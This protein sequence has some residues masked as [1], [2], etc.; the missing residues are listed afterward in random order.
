MN[1]KD[2]F[3]PKILITGGIVLVLVVIIWS[4]LANLVAERF[5]PSSTDTL[6]IDITSLS[7]SNTCVPKNQVV[8]WRSTKQYTIQFDANSKCFNA[9][10]Y[11][12]N[13]ACSPAIAGYKCSRP[14]SPAQ[15]PNSNGFTVCHYKL[16]GGLVDPRIIVIGK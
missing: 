12:V 9:T 5:C 7:G 13:Q 3:K 15:Q 6:W 16:G 4:P 14:T 2:W 8:G 11:I 1:V 10:D